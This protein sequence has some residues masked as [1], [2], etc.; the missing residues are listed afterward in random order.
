MSLY[1]G[2]SS[3]PWYEASRFAAARALEENFGLIREEARNVERAAFHRES[4]GLQ[5]SGAWDVFMLYQR[6]R[7]IAE[8]CVL[9]PVTTQIVEEHQT[10]RTLAGAIY[11]SRMSPGTHIKPHRGTTNMRVRCH[12][13]LEV[14]DGDCALRAGTEI[15]QWQQGRAMVFDDYYEHEAWNN[16]GEDRIVLIVDLWHPQLTPREIAVIEGMQRYAF[17]HARDL[18]AYWSG[19]ETARTAVRRQFA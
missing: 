19:N 6:G 15:R 10:V 14:P 13:A 8:N 11:F 17:L 5:R 1:P 2:L 12:L 16:T 3:R 7:K 18:C 9:C 4:E